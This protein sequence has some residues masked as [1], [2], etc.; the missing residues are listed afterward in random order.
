VPPLLLPAPPFGLP[1]VPVDVV[2]VTPLSNVV[3]TDG[4]VIVLVPWVL[5]PVTLGPPPFVVVGAFCASAE[6]AKIVVKRTIGRKRFMF[7]S[8][9]WIR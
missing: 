7:Y 1:S 8:I 4:S 9:H 6:L 2:T 5:W 3:C